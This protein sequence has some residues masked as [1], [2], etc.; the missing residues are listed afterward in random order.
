MPAAGGPQNS[1]L[2][3]MATQIHPPRPDQNALCL[4]PSRLGRLTAAA[5]GDAAVRAQNPMPGQLAAGWQAGQNLSDQPRPPWQSR[6]TGHVAVGGDA[7]LGNGCHHQPDPFP[8]RDLVCHRWRLRGCYTASP[9]HLEPALRSLFLLFVIM[10]V[11]ELYVLIRVGQWLGAWPTIGLVFLTAVVGVS[12]LRQQGF[13][14]LRIVRSKLDAG[15]L[16]AREMVEGLVLVVGGAMFLAP[17]F[18]TD[19]FG[20]ICLLPPTRRLLANWLLTR[21]IWHV[22]A[23]PRSGGP[24]PGS[25]GRIIE[26]EFEREDDPRP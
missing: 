9:V 26:G 6:E 7:A 18:I 11:M 14:T 2:P 24:P 17:G 25:R 5:A 8:R 1:W 15:E 23:G 16:P 21:G 22:Q 13:A 20:F 12:L 4:E 10:P 3:A 19:V